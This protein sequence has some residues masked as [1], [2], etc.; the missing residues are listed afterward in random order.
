[1]NSIQKITNLENLH[2]A[3]QKAKFFY[4]PGDTWFNEVEVLKFEANLNNELNKIKEQIENN[5]YEMSPI[6]PIAFPKSKDK[7]NDKPRTRQTFYISVR[8]QVTW[9]AV[10]NII[11]PILD[12]KMPFWSYGNRLFISVFYEEN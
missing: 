4:K 3:W 1:M 10:T 7:D 5:N 12:Y 11:G 9:L 8:D 6:R 2:W